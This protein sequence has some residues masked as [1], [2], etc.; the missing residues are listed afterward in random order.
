MEGRTLATY[1]DEPKKAYQQG[2]HR[3]LEG[4]HREEREVRR[5][6]DLTGYD[7]CSL[8][9]INFDTY[10]ARVWTQGLDGPAHMNCYLKWRDGKNA[11]R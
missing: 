8:C 9:K 11:V 7:R 5:R 10:D 1:V 2:L 3:R 4:V 6:I